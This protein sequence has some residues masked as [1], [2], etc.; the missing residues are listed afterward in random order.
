MSTVPKTIPSSAGKSPHKP[1]QRDYDAIAN[2]TP[3]DVSEDTSSRQYAFE[4]TYLSMLTML[5][6]IMNDIARLQKEVDDALKCAPTPQDK[7]M[8]V[9]KRANLDA[10]VDLLRKFA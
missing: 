3:Q 1:K 5:G 8:I 2:N 9:R 10:A 4:R 7:D 6:V